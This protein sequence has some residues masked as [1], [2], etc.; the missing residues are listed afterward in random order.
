MG[1]AMRVT[2]NNLAKSML[3][4]S[5][6]GY[7]TAETAFKAPVAGDFTAVGTALKKSFTDLNAA[8]T[9][10]K[11]VSTVPAGVKDAST[12]NPKNYAVWAPGAANAAAGT[13]GSYQ[14]IGCP[15]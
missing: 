3:T 8:L 9:A 7:G 5:A 2:W 10:G 13:A 6:S 15:Y 11:A 12:A 14:K 4:T 1:A